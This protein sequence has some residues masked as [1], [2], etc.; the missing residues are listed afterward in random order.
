MKNIAV[1]IMLFAAALGLSATSVN[2]QSSE[3]LAKKLSN[4][5]ASLISV[6]FQFNYDH[7]YGPEDGDKATLNIQPVI[8]FSLNEDW[9]L[10]SRTILPVTWQN[11]IAGPS[12]TQFGLGDTLQSFFLSPSKPTESGIVWG[13][14][15]VFLLPTATDEL[16]GSGKW[17]AGPTAVVL[18]QD[19][20][21]TY[22]M[23]SNHIWSF[24]GQ[25]DRRDVSSTFL[26][27]FISYTT[28]DAW[29]FSLNTESTYDWETNNWS[30]PI[31][32]TVAK[33]ITIDKQPISLTA[34]IR[35]WA[36]AP[37][38]GPEGIGF[39]VALTFLFPK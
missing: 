4:P 36:D 3:E 10:I 32:F 31:N 34:G 18:K 14:G 11:D 39:R 8:P 22:G 7:G 25:S 2:A 27:P 13:A 5:I 21:W 24:A 1:C 17:G 35:Y 6:P 19:G 9:N 15:P 23:L 38:N 16:L 20:P 26:Q 12:G 33:L 30:V 29:T 37:E 28:K